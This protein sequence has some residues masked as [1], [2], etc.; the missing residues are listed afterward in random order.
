MKPRVVVAAAVVA[1][2]AATAC[3]GS[4][5]RSDSAA[6]HD[7]AAAA[8]SGDTATPAE[9]APVPAVNAPDDGAKPPS[10]N[11]ATTGPAAAKRPATTGQGPTTPT[12]V[13]PVETRPGNQAPA[14]AGTPALVVFRDSVGKADLDWLR[15]QGFTIVNVNE[16]AHAVSVTVPDGYSGNPKANPRVLRFTIAMR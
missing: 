9:P 13:V 3:R 16:A 12:V 5:A 8:L 2:V 6:V 10:A 11:P 4:K 15:A 7:T 1:A 14:G